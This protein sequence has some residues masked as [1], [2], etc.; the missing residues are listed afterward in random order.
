MTEYPRLRG[1]EEQM[2]GSNFTTLT[3]RMV[4][5]IFA[6]NHGAAER[7]YYATRP[8]RA[9]LAWDATADMYIQRGACRRTPAARGCE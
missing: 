1:W 9:A 7:E 4:D 8:P 5:E 6:K 3:D 2:R